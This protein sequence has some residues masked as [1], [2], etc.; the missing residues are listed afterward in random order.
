MTPIDQTIV[1]LRCGSH[2]SPGSCATRFHQRSDLLC[3]SNKMIRVPLLI[4]LKG[5]CYMFSVKHPFTP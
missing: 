2:F 4:V 3:I 5:L 1:M